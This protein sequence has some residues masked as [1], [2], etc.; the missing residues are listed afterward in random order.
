MNNEEDNM[1]CVIFTISEDFGGGHVEFE[2]R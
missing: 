2:G 1:A